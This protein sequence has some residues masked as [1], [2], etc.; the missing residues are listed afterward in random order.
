MLEIHTGRSCVVVFPHPPSLACSL[1]LALAL[2]SR[3]RSDSMCMM[4]KRARGAPRIPSTKFHAPDP[5]RFTTSKF[6]LG[7]GRTPRRRPCLTPVF[8]AASPYP[9]PGVVGSPPHPSLRPHYTT[10]PLPFSPRAP[11]TVPTA[12]R[13]RAVPCSSS[14]FDILL[15]AVQLCLLAYATAAR[16]RRC[17]CCCC[18]ISLG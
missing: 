3:S 17:R 10:S 16:V 7:T 9:R 6:W 2:F 15:F 1:S 12:T 8:S 5:N 18:S 14:L 4:N 13:A 11:P